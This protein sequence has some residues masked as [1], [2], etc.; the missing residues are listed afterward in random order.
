MKLDS[1]MTNHPVSLS[2]ADRRPVLGPLTSI[3]HMRNR[4]RQP[5]AASLPGT[6]PDPAMQGASAQHMAVSKA[7]WLLP[8]IHPDMYALW[9][10][11]AGIL[12]KVVKVP[13]LE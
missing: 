3:N 13:K 8:H 1:C 9:F 5:L 6:L 12:A 2:V 4:H 11:D 10:M 7:G